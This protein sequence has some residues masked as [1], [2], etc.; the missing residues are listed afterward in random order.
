MNFIMI[1]YDTNYAF[2]WF[3][4]DNLVGWLIIIWIIPILA[5]LLVS[6]LEKQL[7]S[8]EKH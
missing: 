7:L 8:T 1:Y 2:V 5:S 6:D 4:V 3:Y